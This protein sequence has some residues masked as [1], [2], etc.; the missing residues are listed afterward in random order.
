[1]RTTDKTFDVITSDPIDPWVKGCAALNT[2]EYY[3]MCKRHLNEGGVMA[4]WIPLYESSEETAKSVI[5]TFFQVFPDG[6][7]WTND[8][9]NQGY[10]AILF[11]Q[12]GGTKIDVAAMQARLDLP[13][14]FPIKQSLTDVGF[15]SAIELLSTYAG[16]ATDLQEWGKDALINTDLNLRLQYVAGFYL[17]TFME[18][19]ILNGIL[20]HYVF[21]TDLFVGAQEQVDSLRLSLENAGRP[22]GR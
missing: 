22:I 13:E 17:N 20:D 7:L 9:D 18:A 5:A 21:P 10:D 16:R 12:K 4:L 6:I 1:M 2:V 11:G 14:N 8:V 19:E 15:N 3:E